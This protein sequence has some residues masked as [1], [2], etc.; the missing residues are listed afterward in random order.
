MLKK[1]ENKEIRQDDNLQPLSYSGIV[2]AQRVIKY[3]DNLLTGK[4]ARN[5]FTQEF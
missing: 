2:N 3:A 4:N 1:M 5:I